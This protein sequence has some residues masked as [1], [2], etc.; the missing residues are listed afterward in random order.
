M[1][2]IAQKNYKFKHLT[3]HADIVTFIAI[4]TRLMRNKS[5]AQVM[6]CRTT[7]GVSSVKTV[8]NKGTI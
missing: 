5:M 4:F 6:D 3:K 1:R 7:A 2:G 8:I